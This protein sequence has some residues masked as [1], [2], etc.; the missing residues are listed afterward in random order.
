LPPPV[1]E[2]ASMS[3]S[4]PGVRVAAIRKRDTTPSR[5]SSSA[6]DNKKAIAFA[7]G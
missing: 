3:M 4:T 5:R 1:V 6:L 7:P 2:G